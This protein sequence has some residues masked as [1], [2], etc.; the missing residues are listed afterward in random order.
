[1]RSMGDGS[2]VWGPAGIAV[3]VVSAKHLGVRMGDWTCENREIGEDV[4]V[5][6][7]V[8]LF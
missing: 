5:D 6:C 2:R 7:L 3:N 8:F 4:E 1:M